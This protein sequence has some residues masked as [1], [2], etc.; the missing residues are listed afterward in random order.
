MTQVRTPAGSSGSE[1]IADATQYPTARSFDAVQGVTNKLMDGVE[2]L[3]IADETL[4]S[5]TVNAT[6]TDFVFNFVAKDK[7]RI[8]GIQYTN[9][10]VAANATNGWE[11]EFINVSSSNNRVAYFGFGAGTEAVKATDKT[12][13]VAAS[14]VASLANSLSAATSYFNKGDLIQVTAD[15]DDTTIVGQFLLEV[16]YE[17]KGR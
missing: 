4:Y 2:M 11:L 13:A 12:S 17:S 3:P 5:G 6:S 16:S 7:G 1:Y 15:R 14:A 10:A 9:G 8:R